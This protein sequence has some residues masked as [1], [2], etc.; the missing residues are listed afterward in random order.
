MLYLMKPSTP[1]VVAHVATRKTLVV[2]SIASVV[3]GT[4]KSR[5]CSVN[6]A[7]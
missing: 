2:Y 7:A 6:T 5:G 1:T 3:S 4:K